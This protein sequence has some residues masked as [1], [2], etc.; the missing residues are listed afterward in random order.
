M[1]AAK[2]RFLPLRT[3]ARATL[4]SAGAAAALAAA[5]ALTLDGGLASLALLGIGAFIAS[6]L[7]AVLAMSRYVVAGV[8]AAGSALAIGAGLAFLRLIG[9]AWDTDPTVV[10]SVSSRDADPF[11][12]G[13]LA[14][15]AATL[16]VLLGGAVW[17]ETRRTARSPRRPATRPG[18]RPGGTATR[19][20]PGRIPARTAARP[21]PV[22]TAV[23]A[24]PRRP[25]RA[26]SS[27]VSPSSSRAARRS[28]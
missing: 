23:A 17:P 2:S 28:A 21:A 19:P 27:A 3:S 11:F 14:A 12:L 1:P 7:Y 15:G 5:A 16:T 10:T 20:G 22:R 8:A 24:A 18:Q 13:A 25:G 4:W 9:L 26:A 6:A